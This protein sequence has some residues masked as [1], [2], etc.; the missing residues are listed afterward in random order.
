MYEKYIIDL[1][2]YKKNTFKYY[3]TNFYNQIIQGAGKLKKYK[4]QQIKF[5]CFIFYTKLI[6]KRCV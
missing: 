2:I 3:K 5:K 6:L 4:L 1:N